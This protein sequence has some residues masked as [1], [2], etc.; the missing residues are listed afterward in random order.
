M[1]EAEAESLSLPTD[2]GEITILENHIPLV[3]NLRAGEIKFKKENSEEFFVVS[4]GVL[5]VK[6]GNEVVVLADTA[7]FGHEIDV[8]RAEEA[9]ERARKL[10]S[11]SYKDEKTYAESTALLEKNL[12]R[13]KVAKKH[14][15]RTHKNL[16]SGSLNE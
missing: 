13:L 16:E 11:E 6:P 14:R 3:A 8:Q 4:G 1:I 7:E 12:A 5:E 15:T 10:M 2:L 9:R